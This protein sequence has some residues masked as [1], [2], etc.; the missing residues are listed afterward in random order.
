MY[1]VWF[2]PAELVCFILVWYIILWAVKLLQI[3]I[4]YYFTWAPVS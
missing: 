3:I 2:T 4:F 1:V